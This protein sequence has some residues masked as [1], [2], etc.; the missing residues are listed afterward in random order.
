ML[1]KSV[2][3]PQLGAFMQGMKDRE[4][5]L[6]ANLKLE[7]L[8]PLVQDTQVKAVVSKIGNPAERVSDVKLTSNEP[9]GMVKQISDLTAGLKSLFFEN[10]QIQKN[11]QDLDKKRSYTDVQL[12]RLMKEKQLIKINGVL[13]AQQESV[14]M[15]KVLN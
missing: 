12:E 3:D 11:I 4:K 13:Q 9:E 15:Q 6:K 1:K 5:N 2:G 8:N 14:K 7:K 10:K